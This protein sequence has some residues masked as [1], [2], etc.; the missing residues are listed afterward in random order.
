MIE[1]DIQQL[2]LDIRNTLSHISEGKL[3]GETALEKTSAIEKQ[4]NQLLNSLKPDNGQNS[5]EG[6]CYNHNAENCSLL[7][8][9]YEMNSEKS[10][11]ISQFGGKDLSDKIIPILTRH[12]RNCQ[13]KSYSAIDSETEPVLKNTLHL[14]P[15]RK[16]GKSLITVASLSSSQL[17]DKGMFIHFG[18]FLD[19]L[20]PT[21]KDHPCG[22]ID[23]FH[24][25]KAYIERNLSSFDLHAQIYLFPDLDKIFSHAGTHT[26]FDVSASIEKQMS[27]I[28]GDQIPRFTISLKEYV[29][30]VPDDKGHGR[31]D[32]LK[33]DFIY[34]GIPLPHIAKSI[35]LDR[36]DAFYTFIDTLF[37]MSQS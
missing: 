35:A 34:K 36:E 10:S 25:I 4:F 24:S 13:E 20:F 18:N 32:L 16:S 28:W 31:N 1:N 5:L 7:T 8:G 26:L 37:S 30:I 21:G 11:C 3:K 23:T 33:S 9:I 17:F 6:L 19:M 15:F 12:A 14:Y 29:V 27:D 2:A 22:V